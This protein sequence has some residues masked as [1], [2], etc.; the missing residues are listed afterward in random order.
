VSRFGQANYA[1][2]NAFL[3]ALAQHRRHDGLPGVS[4]AW[5]W[6]AQATGMTEH[7]DERGRARMCRVGFIP[8]SSED[9]LALFDA[10]LRQPRSFVMPAQL[11]LAAIQSDSAV[12]G[13]PSMFRGLIRATPSTAESAAAVESF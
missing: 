6:W 2:A 11:D 8:M 4:L 5:G 7:L 9:G 13:L 12:T 3:D 1:A 10:A